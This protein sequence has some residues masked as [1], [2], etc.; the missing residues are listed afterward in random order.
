MVYVEIL[1]MSWNGEFLHFVEDKVRIVLVAVISL[2]EM[3]RERE[4]SAIIKRD[5]QLS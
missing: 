5:I 4:R 3:K 2:S 1:S